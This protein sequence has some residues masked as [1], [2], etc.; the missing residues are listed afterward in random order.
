ME[1]FGKIKKYHEENIIPPLS[2]FE[3]E[4]NSICDKDIKYTNSFYE[5]KN[6]LAN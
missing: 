6:D 4:E 3:Y 5:N 1:I 2:I